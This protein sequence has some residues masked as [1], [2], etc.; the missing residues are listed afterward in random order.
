MSATC[1][2]CTAA[3][4]VGASP[5]NH[6]LPIIMTIDC[7]CCICCGGTI[8]QNGLEESTTMQGPERVEM[9]NKEFIPKKKKR[10]QVTFENRL[11]SCSEPFPMS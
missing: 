4:C 6:I 1:A 8:E 5:I 7:C 3:L 11:H 9:M 2:Y 10:K